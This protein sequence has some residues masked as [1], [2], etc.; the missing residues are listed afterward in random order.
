MLNQRF[1][2]LF[3]VAGLA[4]APL[5]AEA[6]TLTS[7]VFTA[8]KDNAADI[9]TLNMAV[10]GF[11]ATLNGEMPPASP[12]NTP[13][14]VNFPDGHRSINW[15]AAPPA[16][17]QPNPFPGDFFNTDFFPRAR[18]TAFSPV[19]GAAG[20]TGFGLSRASTDPGFM[21]GEELF[22]LAP[23][24]FSAFSPERIFAVVGTNQFDVRFFD[25]A[26]PSQRALVDGFGAIFVDPD[27]PGSSLEFFDINNASLGIVMVDDL[28]LPTP[29]GSIG[30]AGGF[31]DMGV[32]NIWR[33]RVTVGQTGLDA[34]GA[35]NDCVALDDFIF[36]EPVSADEPS[37]LVVLASAGVVYMIGNRRRRRA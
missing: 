6:G 36:G 2:I 1:R 37:A 8:D 31:D 17:S 33:V 27:Q 23:F 3:A 32:A 18:G 24:G 12:P 19:G 35:S 13:D 25:P 4:I 15:D 30:F 7:I 14:G 5:I 28:V 20:A 11:R 21:P 29:S 26:N 34:C 22:G 10:D 9:D 16:V